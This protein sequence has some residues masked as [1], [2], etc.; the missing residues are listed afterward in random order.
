[1][2]QQFP[3]P[4]GI[5]FI[6]K[7]AFRYWS[8]TLLYQV[9]FSLLYFSVFLCSLFYFANFFGIFEQY[10]L[11]SEKLSEGFSAYQQGVQDLAKNPNFMKFQ[12]AIMLTLTFLYPLNLGLFKIYRKLDLNEPLKLED[13]FAGYSGINFFIY[14]GYFLF[15][16]MVYSYAAS[17]IILGIIW[18]F[19]TLFSAPLMFFMDKRIFETFSPNVQALKRFPMEIFVGV[20]VAVFFRYFGLFTILGAVFTFPFWNAMIYALYKRIFTEIR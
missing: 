9:A 12:L 16:F 2:Q 8:R 3:Q 1:M 11:L 15:W 19:L 17:T 6:L 4:T 18:V 20:F 13:L 14:F 5:D 10:L 7:T